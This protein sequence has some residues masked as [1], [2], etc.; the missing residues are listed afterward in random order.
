MLILCTV[1]VHE[2]IK[3][4]PFSSNILL[5]Q[6]LTCHRS[7]I[8]FQVKKCKRGKKSRKF[9]KDKSNA[10]SN[11]YSAMNMNAIHTKLAMDSFDGILNRIVSRNRYIFGVTQ[12]HI[13]E[14]D[15]ILLKGSIIRYS[16]R[17]RMIVLKY[18]KN[19][20]KTDWMSHSFQKS[21]IHFNFL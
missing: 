15:V 17:L 21:Q 18:Q 4:F 6:F 7:E 11:S 14:S 3:T 20:S 9:F 5:G 16:N 19:F 2:S 1:T 8:A 13:D 10:F 12:L